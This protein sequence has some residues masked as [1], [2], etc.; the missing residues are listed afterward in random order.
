MISRT[1]IKCLTCA[2]AITARIQV[3]HENLQA[4]VFPCPLCGTEVKLTMLL[5]APP[6][7]KINWDENCEVG[8]EEGA[9]VNVGAGFT[10]SKDRVS[11]PYYFP[12]VDLVPMARMRQFMD[13]LEH[14]PADGS[15]PHLIDSSVA[16][17][18]LPHS[19]E[20][21]KFIQKA[22]RFNST[23]QVALRD[24]Q[25]DSFWGGQK[26]DGTTLESTVFAFFSRML[27][28]RSQQ[29][30]ESL[31]S[32]LDA[33]YAANPIELRRLADDFAGSW[34]KER[35]DSYS[36]IF[37]EYF[38]GFAEFDQ[39][40]VYARN[41][42]QLNEEHFASSSDFDLTRMFYG[43]AFEL[44][45]THLDLVA[46]VNNVANGRNYE[47][48]K[49][50]D[51][52]QFRGLNKANR[53]ACFSE[54]IELTWFVGEYDSVVRN[55]SHHRWFRLDQRRLNISYRSGGTGALRSMSYAEYLFRC[56][57]LAIQLMAMV[58][59]DLLFLKRTGKAI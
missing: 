29:I 11:D 5:D 48:M 19:R 25:I 38:R 39:T 18:N 36:E 6:R 21:W 32:A 45:G 27:A 35:F 51:L 4:V 13:E 46:A 53:T 10:I 52:K 14:K 22:L 57:K 49:A 50:M 37:N 43:N 42:E 58:C 55:A 59:W 28:P 41:G 17:G 26:P 16:L 47:R 7:V 31:G 8:S 56:N 23:G 34:V 20:G 30:I 3:G 2:G 24:G 54:N 1:L 12:S 40:L 44:L 9:I 15:G 33:A